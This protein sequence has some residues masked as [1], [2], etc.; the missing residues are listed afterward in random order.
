MTSRWMR[1]DEPVD[2]VAMQVARELGLGRRRPSR[3]TVIR[4]AGL[5]AVALGG[6][7]LSGCGTE[8]T[9][10]TEDSCK[11]EDLSSEEKTINFSNW[12]LYID[13]KKGTYPTLV[14]FEE[15]TG[16]TVNYTTDINDNAEF[17]GKIRNQLGA[18]EST[19]RDIFA[20]TDW[21]AARIVGLGWVQEL[22]MDNM[23]NVEANLLPTLREPEWD[24]G[25]KHS[26]PW[27][28]GLTGIAY[29]A[30]YTGEVKSFEEL[31]TRPD[32]K[33]KVSLLSEMG[34]TMGFFLRMEG[35]DP[36]DF[37]DDE[38][39]SALQRLEEVVAS[40]QIRQFTGNDY[41]RP[42]NKGDLVA[43]EAWSGDAIMLQA[44]N[45]DIKFV[46]PEEGASLWSDNMMVPNKATHKTNAEELMNYYYDP[47]VAARLAAWVWYMSPVQGAEEAMK[48]VD[49]SLVGN[50]LVFPT[51][52]DLANTFGALGFTVEER[53]AA[54]KE[55]NQVIGG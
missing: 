16:I 7:A 46:V 48:K 41:T 24:P 54:E 9:R 39:G 1:G 34:D 47:E 55:F 10:Q 32:L 23:P 43:S 37:T 31:V 38:W 20:L 45:P 44:D 50:P 8:G 3:R 30:K 33:G 29:N 21:M 19:E 14:D 27:Q 17:F 5:S 51:E 4:G 15:Q 22:N 13:E 42:L 35:A 36:E 52:D 2:R 53:E 26:V 28:S 49:K 18:C 40:G 12:P 25:R 6:G 11:S